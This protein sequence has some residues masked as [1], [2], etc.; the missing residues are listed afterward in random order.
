[1]YKYPDFATLRGKTL[2]HISIGRDQV[3]LKTSDGKSYTMYHDQG[4]CESVVIFD[5]KGD[6]QS[7]LGSPLTIAKEET[8]RDWPSDVEPRSTDSHTWSIYTLK[9]AKSQHVV[10]RWLGESN[11]YYGETVQL[12]EN[13]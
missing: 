10:I 1:M 7:L 6:P 3:D 8:H 2:T 12:S 4:C 9:T 11:G 5:T 13:S